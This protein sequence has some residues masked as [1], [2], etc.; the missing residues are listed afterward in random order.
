MLKA[1][2]QRQFPYVQVQGKPTGLL[3][4]VRAESRAH[5]PA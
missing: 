3:H 4:S 2:E 1:T 5:T